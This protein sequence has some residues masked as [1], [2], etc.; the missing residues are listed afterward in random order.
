MFYE[1]DSEVLVA[2]FGTGDIHIMASVLAGDGDII[3]SISL[4]DNCGKC[5][6]IGSQID[7]EQWEGICETIRDDTDLNTVVRLVFTRVESIDVL[8]DALNETKDF[9][10]GAKPKPTLKITL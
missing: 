1:D 3:G 6:P 5:M 4:I 2:Q 7:K 8:I 9:M 10:T